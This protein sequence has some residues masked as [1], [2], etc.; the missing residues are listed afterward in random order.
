MKAW[1]DKEVK[2]VYER[3]V[4]KKLRE[5]R[6][7]IRKGASVNDL[8]RLLKGI[9]AAAAVVWYRVFRG[10]RKERAWWTYEIKEAIEG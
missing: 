5:T 3:K 6:M 2:E 4:C 9:V 10:R 1:I 7:T 8:F